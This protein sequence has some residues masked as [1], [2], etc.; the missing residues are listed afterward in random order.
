MQIT[1]HIVI[2]IV[3]NVFQC[4]RPSIWYGSTMWQLLGK[5]DVPMRILHFQHFVPHMDFWN[6]LGVHV[7]VCD[8]PFFF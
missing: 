8:K 3:Q 2:E 1:I 6:V 7:S 5:K 4:E